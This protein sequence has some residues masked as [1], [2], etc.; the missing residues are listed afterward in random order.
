MYAA[1]PEMMGMLVTESGGRKML[2]A[3]ALMMVLG[4]LAIRKIVR[5]RL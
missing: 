2:G 5:I 3:A 1:N 4:V